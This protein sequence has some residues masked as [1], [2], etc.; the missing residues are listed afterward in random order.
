[1]ENNKETN[2][3]KIREA[4]K[5]LL[6]VPFSVI[7]DIPLFVSRLR[8]LLTLKE[9]DISLK[10]IYNPQLTLGN[11]VHVVLSGNLNTSGYYKVKSINI[12]LSSGGLTYSLDLA[13]TLVTPTQ[14]G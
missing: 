12:G 13:S 1:M 6:L 8:Q 9:K 10:G 5:M 14:G 7:E 11:L 2:L 3:Q 4:T